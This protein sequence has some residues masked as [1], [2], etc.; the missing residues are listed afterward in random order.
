MNRAAVRR[1]LTKMLS[2]L[3]TC[4]ASK[5]YAS[6]ARPWCP[7]HGAVAERLF[8]GQPRRETLIG[9]KVP[10]RRNWPRN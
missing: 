1:I 2:Q 10:N 9:H 4:K 3:E 6:S 7:G 5:D 8:E